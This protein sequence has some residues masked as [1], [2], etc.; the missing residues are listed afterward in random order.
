MARCFLHLV[1]LHFLL[2]ELLL[3]LRNTLQLPRLI[4]VVRSLGLDAPV[5]GLNRRIELI[6]PRLQTRHLILLR[7]DLSLPMVGRALFRQALFYKTAFSGAM[8]SGL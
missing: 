5:R 7:Q 4:P 6:D 8:V 2:I 3:D 1:E